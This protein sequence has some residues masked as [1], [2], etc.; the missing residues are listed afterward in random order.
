LVFALVW[1]LEVVWRRGWRR[2]AL[3]KELVLMW[4]EGMEVAL[5]LML[6]LVLVYRIEMVL[7]LGDLVLEYG[8]TLA[9]GWSG[10]WSLS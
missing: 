8:L 7:S 9:W 5:E 2:S 10:G 3:R 6:E 1:E 4:A